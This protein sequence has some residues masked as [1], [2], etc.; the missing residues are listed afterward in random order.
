MRHIPVLLFSILVL[1]T[2]CALTGHSLFRLNPD[3]KDHT[4]LKAL[5]LKESD[6]PFHFATT[7]DTTWGT[8]L[9]VN[10]WS[11]PVVPIWRTLDELVRVHPNEALVIVRHDTV[12]FEHY[13]HTPGQLN[14]SYSVAKS[15]TSALVG[16]AV[17][18]GLIAMTDP[19]AKHLPG[20]SNDP[21]YELVTLAQLLNHTSGIEHPLVVDGLLYYGD[22]TERAKKFIRFKHLPGTHQ[23]YM[24]MN[25]HLLGRVL[26]KVTG[27]PLN[28]YMQKKLWDPLGMQNARWS[29]D[30]DDHIK[31]YCCLQATAL[32]YARFGR[33][34]LNKGEWQGRQL[35]DREWIEQSIV[36][37]TT[38]GGTF[39]YHNCWYIGYKDEMDFVAIGLYKQ[40]LYINPRKGVIIVSLND[41]PHGYAQR[42]L[43]WE[44]VC[45]Q[46]V[47]Q[48]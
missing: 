2:G 31:P 30:A 5:P 21:R 34:Y 36:R 10:D 33:L 35:L 8:R 32:D 17:Q 25:I 47:D 40:H 1:A 7:T 12:L 38:Q 44:D 37:D 20:L 24:N 15:F 48:L 11:P 27:A 19:V 13:A 16:F 45:R 9:R 14:P 43:I 4:W 29:A 18:D 3:L 23:A 26:E 39:G 41:R 28:Q 22:R 42:K 6:T 46:I